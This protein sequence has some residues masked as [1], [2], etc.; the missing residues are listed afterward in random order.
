VALGIEDD[1]RGDDGTG[2][3]AAPDFVAAGDV[4]EADAPERVLQR[5]RR[6]SAH[7]PDRSI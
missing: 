7:E 5:P 4:T 6:R 1:R 3:A 2:Q